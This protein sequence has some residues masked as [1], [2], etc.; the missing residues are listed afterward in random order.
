MSID[1]QVA[2][3][4]Q[5][6]PSLKFD[7]DRRF[8][9]DLVSAWRRKHRLSQAQQ[10]WVDKLIDMAE[11]R[12]EELKN[13]PEPQ[14]DAIG[15]DMSKLHALFDKARAKD[16]QVPRLR[17]M[18]A[19]GTKLTFVG[20]KDVIYINKG[21]SYYGKIDKS[22]CL[23]RYRLIP[24]CQEVTDIAIAIGEN[25]AEF[26]KAQGQRLKWCMFCGTE[27][28]T[29]ESLYYGYGPICAEKWGLP[30]EDGRE[31][32]HLQKFAEATGGFDFQAAVDKWKDALK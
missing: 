31:K 5:L 16:V 29:I 2:K 27:L 19:D 10:L 28:R 32:H 24:E 17:A 22:Q 6:T 14:V 23:I 21:D 13:P 30:W 15:I 25:P 9:H 7:N 8:A 20:K 4:V 11:A 18:M 26:G 12:I 3:L 1:S